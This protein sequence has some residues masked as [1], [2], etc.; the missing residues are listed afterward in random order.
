MDKSKLMMIIIIALLVLLLGTVV[1]VT[2]YLINLVGDDG[3]FNPHAI[4]EVASPVNLTLRDLDEVP[5]GTRMSVNLAI[6]E[7]GTSDTAAFEIVLGINGT[8]DRS[9]V[10]ALIADINARQ[11]MARGIVIGVFGDLTYDEVRTPEGRSAAAEEA[12]TR[13]QTAFASPLIVLVEF[14]EWFAMRGV[15]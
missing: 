4:E 6:G 3:N 10:D 11:G 9:E 13:L 8:G 5:L 2:F 15:R 1:G 12:M 7:R 14:S